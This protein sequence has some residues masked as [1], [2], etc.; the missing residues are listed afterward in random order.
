[1][2]PK[3]IN[4]VKPFLKPSQISFRVFNTAHRANSVLQAYSTQLYCHYITQTHNLNLFFLHCSRV[5]RIFYPVSD[6]RI[7]QSRFAEGSIYWEEGRKHPGQFASPPEGKNTHTKTFIP[8][9]LPCL[10]VFE[11]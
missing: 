1:M 5:L 2:S 8:S 3:H 10:H 6:L 7:I 9:V 11:M 4:W